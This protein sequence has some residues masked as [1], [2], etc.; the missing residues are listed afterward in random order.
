[1]EIIAEV[2]ST[3]DGSL[4][5]ALGSIETAARCGAT[6]CKFQTHIAEHETLHDA[7]NPPYFAGE[8]RYQYF[9]RT[10]FTE[11]QYERL[12]LACDENGVEFVSSPFCVEAVELLERVGCRNYKIP[13]GEVSNLPLIERLSEV[14]GRVYL[15]SGMSNWA[16]LDRAFDFL[17]ACSSLV[18]MQC[19]SE[20][21]CK[22][23][24]VG[25]NVFSEMAERYG[26][27]I[28]FSDHTTGLA[29]S[30]LAVS[31]GV[32]IIEKHFTLSRLLYGSDAANSLDPDQFS[33]FC[34]ELTEAEQIVLSRVDKGDAQRYSDMKK[35]FEKSVVARHPLAAGQAVSI[36]DLAY[37]KPGDGIPASEYRALVGKVLSKA[38]GVDHKFSW[39]DFK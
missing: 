24:N 12:V 20:Y 23:E 29:A 16:E 5:N 34:R 39:G 8:N 17:R 37:K 27:T 33:Q 30:I 35:I 28:G 26:C 14:K 19:S 22:P 11:D 31:Q 1:M 15:S 25:L 32:R 10:A 18:V 38:V 6:H 9:E 13:S 4:G 3:H 7:P 36:N 2:G 21:P